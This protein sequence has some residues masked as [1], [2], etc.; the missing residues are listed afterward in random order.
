VARWIR[1]RVREGT[2][3]LGEGIRYEAGDEFV[4]SFT[5][6][7]SFLQEK[8]RRRFEIVDDFETISDEPPD[9]TISIERPERQPG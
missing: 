4:V 6:A 8:G 3:L 1:F 7:A 5:D 9:G 2:F